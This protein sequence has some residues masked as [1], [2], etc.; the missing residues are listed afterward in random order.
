MPELKPSID[1]VAGFSAVGIHAGLKKS[2]ALDMSLIVADGDCV[3]RED[4]AILVVT[5][6]IGVF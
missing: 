4:F 6:P 1:K 2:G 5:V 3:G